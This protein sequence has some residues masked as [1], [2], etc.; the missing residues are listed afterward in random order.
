MAAMS[1]LDEF[2]RK[3]ELRRGLKVS[4]DVVLLTMFLSSI[5]FTISLPSLWLYYEGFTEC[6]CLHPSNRTS[7]H[8]AGPQLTFANQVPIPIQVRPECRLSGN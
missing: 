3:E 4:I 7:L 2:E 6:Q 1:G 8:E 5:G